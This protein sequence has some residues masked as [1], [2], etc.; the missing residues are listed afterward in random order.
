MKTKSQNILLFLSGLCV[1]FAG[2]ISFAFYQFEK[3]FL[4]ILLLAVPKLDPAIA[5]E[6]VRQGMARMGL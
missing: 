6:M 1:G 3:L 5:N 4:K 2:G